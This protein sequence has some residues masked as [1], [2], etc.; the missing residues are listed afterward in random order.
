MNP[1][2]LLSDLKTEI[3]RGQIVVVAGTGVA[4]AA[5]DDQKIDG[6]Q[7]ASWDG[8]LLHGVDYCLN[9]HQVID[10]SEAEVLKMQIKP[11]KLDFLVASAELI[12]GRLRSKSRGTY[13]RWL[14][15]TVG[16]LQPKQPEVF[17]A[18]AGLGGVLTTL[19]YDGLFEQATGR[20]PVT[21][22]ERDKVEDIL[23]GSIRDAVLHLHGYFDA[24]ESVVLGLGSY[25]KVAVDPHTQAVLRFFTLGRTL[26]FIGCGGTFKDPNFSRLLEWANDA[27]GE[28]THRHFRLCREDELSAIRAEQPAAPWLHPVIFGKKFE[29]LVP[30][31]HHL[32]CC[33]NS[34][35][36]V[37]PLLPREELELVCSTGAAVELIAH[38]ISDEISQGKIS[39]MDE[40]IHASCKTAELV[41]GAMVGFRHFV[42][43][44]DG[45]PI[46]NFFETDV[47]RSY[48]NFYIKHISDCNASVGR[49]FAS[50]LLYCR[51]GDTLTICLSEYSRAAMT[52]IL[53]FLTINKGLNVHLVA[54][55]RKAAKS[56]GSVHKQSTN[57]AIPEEIDVA[58][59]KLRQHGAKI[60]RLMNEEEWVEFLHQLEKGKEH[61]DLIVFGA[62]AVTHTGD[63][64]FPQIISQEEIALLT[65]LT[66]TSI[67][68]HA[69]DVVCVAESYKI[70]P[71]G[72]IREARSMPNRGMFSIIPQAAFRSLITDQGSVSFG[73]DPST[74]VQKLLNYSINRS[75]EYIYDC[76]KSRKLV[77][78]DFLPQ[79]ALKKVRCITTDID[80]T[81]TISGRFSEEMICRLNQLR[82]GGFITILVT[83]R[84]SGWAQAMAHYLD[85]DQVI[86]ENGLVVI[87]RGGLLRCIG[88]NPDT[89]IL[90]G[91]RRCTKVL[92]ETF[93]LQKSDDSRFRLCEITFDRPRNFGPDDIES[94]NRLVD[95][96]FEVIASSIQLHLRPRSLSKGDAVKLV[97]GELGIIDM[98]KVLVV[99]DS[100]ND[101]SLFKNFPISVGVA[102]VLTYRDEL[103]E[104]LPRF[105][106]TA[107][108]WGGF[109]E[110]MS[111][112]LRE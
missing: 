26:L 9:V 7:V 60:L 57:A 107:P 50:Y 43:L 13:H 21:W 51:H 35:V 91:L 89:E 98:E 12:T 69:V 38:R 81:I 66:K 27:L 103:G 85:V 58:E 4:I 109:E 59:G 92:E 110:V 33:E 63:I 16:K 56:H 74:G 22:Q 77:P 53:N 97:L 99:G 30:F 14:K 36:D 67:S 102:N 37:E 45:Y 88:P 71:P 3:S 96:H 34:R 31:L 104:D 65:N 6:H 18:L 94:C 76:L 108:E 112:I 5:S 64:V 49:E 101:R 11:G 70:L 61:V 54:R 86:A 24:P 39:S 8:L 84:S 73:V 23:R 44:G 62:E 2:I 100:A 55:S 68:E 19:N 95:S 40:L 41:R 72:A 10:P 48:L 1:N 29:D 82:K 90:E 80:D 32:G 105:I 78:W 20:H 111:R 42:K 93:S 75:R 87:N 106:T 28:T 47:L 17:Q 79:P 25:A 52:G 15:D 46:R 83:G